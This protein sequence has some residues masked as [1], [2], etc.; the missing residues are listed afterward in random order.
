MRGN[1]SHLRQLTLSGCQSPAT[2]PITPTSPECFLSVFV[3]RLSR[4]NIKWRMPECLCSH[5]LLFAFFFFSSHLIPGLKY[6]AL[7]TATLT[8]DRLMRTLQSGAPLDCYTH[9]GGEKKKNRA[10]MMSAW[11]STGADVC[12]IICGHALRGLW[13]GPREG[14]KWLIQQSVTR[15]R[16]TAGIVAWHGLDVQSGA[17]FT[18]TCPADDCSCSIMSVHRDVSMAFRGLTA[19]MCEALKTISLPC[20]FTVYPRI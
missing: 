10:S 18:H 7:Q 12:S 6:P 19:L 17:D 16:A 9:A 4:H 13:V 3:S 8:D 2:K 11:F 20:D 1:W 14:P 15:Y 5:T